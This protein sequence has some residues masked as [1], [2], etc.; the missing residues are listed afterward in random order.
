VADW[1]SDEPGLSSAQRE[2]SRLGRRMW[3]RRA[4]SALVALGLAL[5]MVGMRARKVR[6]YVSRVIYRVTENDLDE[7]TAPRPARQLREY[8]REV[9][10]SNP[11]L[12]DVMTTYGLFVRERAR[13]PN[14]AVEAMRDAISVEVWRNYFFEGARGGEANRSARLS[15]D[16]ED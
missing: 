7:T 12:L 11:R 2:L 4:L 6:T 16:F 9:A 15:I 10:F 1:I 13:D 5:A 8:V 3:R 14:L